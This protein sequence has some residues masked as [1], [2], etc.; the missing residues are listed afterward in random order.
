MILC[1]LY[2][3]IK[4]KSFQRVSFLCYVNDMQISIDQDCQF[5]SVIQTHRS[6][7][8]FDKVNLS[9]VTVVDYGLKFSINSS[10]YEITNIN[11]FLIAD[12]M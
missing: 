3:N 10:K 4:I 6:P 9:I 5:N 8:F 7:S 1:I 11:F 2:P 12:S